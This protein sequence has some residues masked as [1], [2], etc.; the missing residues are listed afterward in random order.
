MGILQSL[1]ICDCVSV[2]DTGLMAIANG[3]HQLLTLNFNLCD[4]TTDAG[5]SAVTNE[6]PLLQSLHIGGSR[7]LVLLTQV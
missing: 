4:S 5:L 7:S 3:L 6:L 1:N 2:T